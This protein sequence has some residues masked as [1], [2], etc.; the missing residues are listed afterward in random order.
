MKEVLVIGK[1]GLKRDRGERGCVKASD[2]DKRIST[3]CACSRPLE[4]KSE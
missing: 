3:D 1:L 2:C 4:P